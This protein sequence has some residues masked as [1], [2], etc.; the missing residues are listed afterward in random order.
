MNYERNQNML[1]VLKKINK[2][3]NLGLVP[4]EDLGLYEALT[5][6]HTLG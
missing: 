4:N 1:I 3:T 6:S 2:L 5:R